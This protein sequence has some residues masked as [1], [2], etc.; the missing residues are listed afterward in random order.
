MNNAVVNSGSIIGAGALVPEGMII[1]ANSIVV[2]IPAKI[3]K[4]ASPQQ[5]ENLKHNA[6]H[7]VQIAKEYKEMEK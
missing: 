5:V 7:Y 1:P 2:G 6:G 4:E 3:I